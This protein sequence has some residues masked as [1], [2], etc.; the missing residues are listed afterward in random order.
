MRW[1]LS[2]CLNELFRWKP[3]CIRLWKGFFVFPPLIT[4]LDIHKNYI[5]KYKPQYMSHK[6]HKHQQLPSYEWSTVAVSAIA[7]VLQHDITRWHCKSGG[8][9]W[10][11]V[12][13]RHTTA[14]AYLD[15]SGSKYLN[16]DQKSR[17]LAVYHNHVNHDGVLR[18]TCSEERNYHRNHQIL[19]KHVHKLFE[20]VGQETIFSWYHHKKH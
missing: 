18:L 13:K 8:H 14:E 15:I 6:K 17:L 9:G 20:L 2:L 10:Q 7:Q 4:I 1:N 16:E 3:F 5:L 11:N 12:N 19:Q